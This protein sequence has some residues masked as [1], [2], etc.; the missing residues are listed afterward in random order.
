V[1]TPE[2]ID[3]RLREVAQVET[4]TRE[5]LEYTTYMAAIERLMALTKET[6][7]RPL[8]MEEYVP[9]GAMG[10]RNTLRELQHYVTGLSAAGLVLTAEGTLDMER[11]FSHLDYLSLLTGVRVRNNVQPL[12]GNRPVDMVT[13]RVPCSSL[14]A[15]DPTEFQADSCVWMTAGEDSQ[16]LLLSRTDGSGRVQLRYVPVARLVQD[17]AGVVHFDRQAWRA[18]LPFRMFEDPAVDL[19]PGVGREEWFDGWHS[20]LEWVHAVH[21]ARYSIGIVG[22]HEQMAPH[23]WA[24]LDVD[25][26]GIETNERLRRR[27]RLRQRALAEPDLLIMASDH[28]NFDVRGFNPGG[29]HGSFLRVSTHA[30]FMVA[31]GRAT[32]VPQGLE[33]T[34]PYDSLSFMPTMLSLT[35]RLEADNEPTEALRR[36]G[37][38]KFPGRV[39]QELLGAPSSGEPAR[40]ER[41]APTD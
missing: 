11:S 16:A 31:G 19:P 23:P 21:R 38:R 27:Y 10:E 17:A 41:S 22:L 35:G 30:T 18:G 8:K 13:L 9:A 12:V 36:R 39:I 5:H 2:Q 25:E 33:V 14:S 26:P 37:F 32:G 7:A 15:T 29:N 34:E 20:D 28:W 24:A 1:E 6:L 40:E 4:W 3:Q